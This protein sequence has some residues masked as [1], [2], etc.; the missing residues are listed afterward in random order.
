MGMG[1]D[2]VE[3]AEVATLGDCGDWLHTLSAHCIPCVRDQTHCCHGQGLR[4]E[5]D[6]A[7]LRSLNPGSDLQSGV[8][9]GKSVTYGTNI[10]AIIL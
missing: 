1:S 7:V 2:E 5:T 3:T 10:A 8:G 4:G 6:I 9:F